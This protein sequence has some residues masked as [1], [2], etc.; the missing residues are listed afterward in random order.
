[1]I[2]GKI[3]TVL[4]NVVGK[5][6]LE[7]TL[8]QGNHVIEEFPA[9]ASDPTFRDPVLPRGCNRGPHRCNFHCAQGGRHFESV[10]GVMIER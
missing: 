2:E 1:M 5:Q 4:G 3:W 10:L 8:V 7:M 6:S 9:A